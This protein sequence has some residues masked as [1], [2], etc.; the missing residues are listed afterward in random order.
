MSE[1]LTIAQA[2]ELSKELGNRRS[3]SWLVRAASKGIIQARKVEMPT[4]VS[5]WMMDKPALI[6]YLST[7]H[8]PG[9]KP[10]TKRQQKAEGNE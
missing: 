2:H 4:G 7:E 6:A 3:V 9:P 10:G 8:K 1:E 5:F